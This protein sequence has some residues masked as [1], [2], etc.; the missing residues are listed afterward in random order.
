MQLPD[1]ATDTGTV[2]SYDDKQVFCNKA[3]LAIRINDFYVSK[4]L[5]IGAHFVL[6]LDY[7]NTSLLKDTVCFLPCLAI[8]VQY[9]LVV[10]ALGSVA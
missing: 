3:Q 10:F 6:A 1:S 7:Q 2:I 5:A 9:R 4:S 8:E